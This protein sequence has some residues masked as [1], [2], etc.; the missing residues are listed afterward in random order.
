MKWIKEQALR[1]LMSVGE[2]AVFCMG[3]L[4]VLALVV[5]TAVL[6]P[7]MLAATITPTIVV[8]L[9]R[10]RSAERYAGNVLDVSA[11]RKAVSTSKQPTG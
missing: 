4:A 10:D 5:A 1:G 7:V 9:M 6:V 2:A 3:V 8:G 11:A